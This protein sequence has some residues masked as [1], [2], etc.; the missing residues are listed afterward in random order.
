MVL[1]EAAMIS[2]TFSGSTAS[3]THPLSL[4]TIDPEFPTEVSRTLTF[5][6]RAVV[7]ESPEE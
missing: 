1:F 5:W 7:V 3:V 6:A 2:C 4:E